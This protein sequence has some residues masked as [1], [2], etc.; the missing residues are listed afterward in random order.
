MPFDTNFSNVLTITITQRRITSRI[1]CDLMLHIGR[2][3]TLLVWILSDARNAESWKRRWPVGPRRPG[4]SHS[5]NHN[6]MHWYFARLGLWR[7]S[8]QKFSALL[9]LRLLVMQTLI[10]HIS[11]TRAVYKNNQHWDYPRVQ[12]FPM[13][14]KKQSSSKG[15]WTARKSLAHYWPCDFS[16]LALQL[17]MH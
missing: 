6:C 17:G 12:G 8:I 16:Q 14:I 7:G 3:R 15:C 10:Y 4:V 1:L 9:S 2:L 5:G 13:R 11:A